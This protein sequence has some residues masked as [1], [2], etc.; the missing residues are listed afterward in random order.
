MLERVRK[1]SRKGEF[2]SLEWFE[3]GRVAILNRIIREGLTEKMT[4]GKG[5]LHVGNSFPVR[6]NSMCSEVGACQ[7]CARCSKEVRAAR[8]E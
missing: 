8:V 6:G 7:E 3:M 1:Y 2:E 4:K 5:R